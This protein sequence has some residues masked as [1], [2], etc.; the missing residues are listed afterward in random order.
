[1]PNGVDNGDLL[2][3]NVRLN[4]N[5]GIQTQKTNGDTAMLQAWDTFMSAYKDFVTMT[6]GNPPTCDLD[7]D[8]TIGGDPIGLITTITGNSGTGGPDA[9][10]D[11]QFLG[12]GGV[13]VSVSSNVATITSSGAGLSWNV[14]G[15]NQTAAVNNGYIFTSGGALTISL[16]AVS[17]PGDILSVTLDGSTSVQITQGVGQRIVYGNQMTTSGATGTLTSTAQGDALILV[18]SVANTRWNVIS[19]MGN[20]TVA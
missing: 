2:I 13:N 15:T 7:V 10:G 8:V 19:S 11:M 14:V 6:A 20:L 16:P 17:A 4:D 1:M 9:T 12:S 5:G 3:N 18:C